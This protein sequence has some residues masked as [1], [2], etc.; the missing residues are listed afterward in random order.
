MRGWLL[1][2]QA[3]AVTSALLG[4]GLAGRA[5]HAAFHRLFAEAA[6]DVDEVG[7]ELLKWIVRTCATRRSLQLAI[8]DTV[9]RKKGPMVFGLGTYLDPVRSSRRVRNFVFGHLWVV[10]VAIVEVPFSKRRWAVPIFFRLYRQ[11]RDCTRTN[12]PYA[13]RT[14]LA[15]E[16]IDLAARVAPELTMH[17]SADAAYCCETVLRGLP[18]N[19]VVYGTLRDNAVLT[20]A[21]IARRGCTGRPRVRGERMP[22]PAQLAADPSRWRSTRAALYGRTRAL[23]FKQMDAQWYQG[24]GPELMRVVV[25]RLSAGKLKHRVYF[26][27]DPTRTPADIVE[28]Y[29]ARWQIEVCFRDLKQHLGFGAS[30]AWSRRAVERVTPFA[31]FVYSIVVMWARL[32]LRRPE[33]APQIRRP[34]YRDK[35][36]L[37]FA[38]L[39]HIARTDLLDPAARTQLARNSPVSDRSRSFA[40]A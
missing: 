15:R 31:G 30:P 17:V 21:P 1:T 22:T 26:C 36:G 39:L 38:D 25:V 24:R 4:A 23:A 9:V 28:R 2:Q 12:D 6:W 3:G 29:T 34:W 5:H 16:L 33:R 35:V 27:T 13:K 18:K 20:A 40:A 14:S 10:L 37:S 19:V 7:T 8:D 11:E 32:S